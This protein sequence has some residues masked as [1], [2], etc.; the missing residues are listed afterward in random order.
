[1]PAVCFRRDL[2]REVS[3]QIELTRI[4]REEVV[5]Q[6]EIRAARLE[7]GRDHVRLEERRHHWR[8]WLVLARNMEPRTN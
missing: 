2:E 3:N 4:A 7:H 6:P 8:S 5:D 1:M